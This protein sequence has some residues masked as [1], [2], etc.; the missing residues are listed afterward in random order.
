[1]RRVQSAALALFCSHICNSGGLL[2]PP[3]TPPSLSMGRV[4]GV[5][6]YTPL[7]PNVLGLY[8]EIYV[9]KI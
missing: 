4:T 1:M 6:K 5:P 2:A 3:Y 9:R 8:H 7:W